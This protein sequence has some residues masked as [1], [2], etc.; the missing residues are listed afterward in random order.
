METTKI[1]TTKIIVERD[2][3]KIELTVPWDADLEEWKE[4]FK[5]LLNWA[6]FSEETIENLF[7]SDD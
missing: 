1:I 3:R 2:I 6:T 5:L 7:K 4:I